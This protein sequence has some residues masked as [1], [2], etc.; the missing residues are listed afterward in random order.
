MLLT[1]DFNCGM[2][3]EYRT[4]VKTYVKLNLEDPSVLR[5]YV[6]YFITLFCHLWIFKDN[7]QG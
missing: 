2:P 6:V 1:L 7:G 3:N 4:L 5:F